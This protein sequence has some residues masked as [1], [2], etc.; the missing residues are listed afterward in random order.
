MAEVFSHTAERFFHIA[1]SFLHV[2]ERFSH[3][4][5]WLCHITEPS[6]YMAKASLDRKTF[7][8]TVKVLPDVANKWP[9][10]PSHPPG[11]ALPGLPYCNGQKTCPKGQKQQ[12]VGFYSLLFCVMLPPKKRLKGA[13]GRWEFMFRILVVFERTHRHCLVPPNRRADS[14][15]QWVAQQRVEY[16]AG[17]LSRQRIRRLERLGFDFARAPE[18]AASNKRDALW[19]R[20]FAEL[21]AYKK[22]HGHC[23]VPDRH[24]ENQKLGNWVHSQRWLRKTGGLKPER[25]LRLDQLGFAWSN[26]LRP[27]YFPKSMRHREEFFNRQW[28]SH[29]LKLSR[30]KERHGYCRVSQVDPALRDLAVW[31]ITQRAL[32]RRGRLSN[33]RRQRL[34]TL[35]FEW[36][37]SHPAW[38]RFLAQLVDF[39]R[40][41]GHF[42]VPAHRPGNRTLANW[43]KIQRQRR[44]D[45]QLAADRVARLNQA[46][47]VW[48]SIYPPGSSKRSFREFMTLSDRWWDIH[49]EELKKFHRKHGHCWIPQT[50]P[51]LR[52]LERW[53]RFQRAAWKR[54]LL[55]EDRR[56]RLEE[57]DFGKPHY[58][59]AWDNHF[60]E[61]L[62][63]KSRFGDCDVPSRW[64]E[65]P[66][67]SGWVGTQR[68]DRKA[69]RLSRER[70][71]RLNEIGFV[72]HSL[73]LPHG[74]RRATPV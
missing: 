10:R 49:F 39:H 65:N 43:V 38:E 15:G 5:K 8:R 33:D 67:L 72:W 32:R 27:G 23:D 45:G 60:A 70:I 24:P 54:G 53:T 59:P 2:T 25:M 68:Y 16:Q 20:R 56:R 62:D 21:A 69:G 3:M 57:L 31:V 64:P 14:L 61:L 40:R 34:D 46:G 51:A 41:F 55:P 22:Q 35:G 50:T 44:Y 12:S 30:F 58:N 7:T 73:R 47:F 4:A 9:F 11:F 42:D 19:A 26:Q 66:V 71:D 48:T 6:G 36:K 52:S 13:F 74:H 1:K 29:F 28:D 37:S 18:Q 17:R 63:Y